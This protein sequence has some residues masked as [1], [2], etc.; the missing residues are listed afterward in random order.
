MM[1]KIEKF[2]GKKIGWKEFVRDTK[3]IFKKLA[4]RS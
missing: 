3:P 1:T 4:R 2:R